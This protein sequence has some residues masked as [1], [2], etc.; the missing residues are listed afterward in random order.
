MAYGTCKGN[1]KENSFKYQLLTEW[2]C[3]AHLS[4]LILIESINVW[5]YGKY[6]AVFMYLVC[7]DDDL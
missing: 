1:L 4:F 7:V 2:R 6:F 3:I 5:L